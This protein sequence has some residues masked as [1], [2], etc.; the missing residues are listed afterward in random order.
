MAKKLYRSR[1]DS[2]LGGVCGGL[3]EYFDIDPVLVRLLFVVFAAFGGAGVPV[4]I[5]LWLIVP[6]GPETAEKPWPDRVRDGAEE[7]A[8]RARHIGAEVRRSSDTPSPAFAFLIGA[9]LVV[10]GFAFLLRNLGVSWM[11][12]VH[13]GTL[14]PLVPIVVGLVFLW[15]WLK[16]GD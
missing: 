3:A 12:W 16:G 5:V 14:W 4:Y 9:V 10:A 1:S 6:E 7:M 2:M 11:R 13:T 15:R 8:D